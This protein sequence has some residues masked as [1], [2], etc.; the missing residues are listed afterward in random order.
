VACLEI[1]YAW[2]GN[3]CGSREKASGV[4]STERNKDLE[5]KLRSFLF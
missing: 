4:E 5:A 1:E 3:E 2:K